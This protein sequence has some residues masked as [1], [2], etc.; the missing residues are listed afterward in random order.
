MRKKDW[1]KRVASAV[2]AAAMVVSQIGVW[3]AG[4]G[5]EVVKAEETNLI[6]NGD[7]SADASGWI[8]TTDLN[9][10]TNPSLTYGYDAAGG[11]N[12]AYISN[13]TGADSHAYFTQTIGS[14]PA[15]T[16]KF[17]AYSMGAGY[18][19]MQAVVGNEKVGTWVN[20]AVYSTDKSSWAKL[21]YTFTVSEAKTDYVVGLY[22]WTYTGGQ[23]TYLDDISLVAVSEQELAYNELQSTISSCESLVGSDYTAESW[24]TLQ[25]ALSTAQAITNTSELSE[26]QDAQTGLK[27]AIA[28][29]EA[30]VIEVYKRD[31]NGDNETLSEWNSSLTTSTTSKSEVADSQWKL[32]SAETT[33]VSLSTTVENLSTGEY[34]LSFVAVGGEMT[35]ENCKVFLK[36]SSQQNE[37]NIVINEWGGYDLTTT[38]L[39]RL[40]TDG[41][42]TIEMVYE[43]LDTNGGGWCNLDDIVLYK[44]VTLEEKKA[45]ELA[46]LNTLIAACDTLNSANYSASTWTAFSSAL[47]TARAVA[48]A[49]GSTLDDISTATKNLKSAKAALKESGIYVQKVEGLSNDFIRGVD[50]S[51]YVSI[52]ESGA[53]FKD[54]NGNVLNDAEFFQLL[55]NSGVNYVRVRIWNDPYTADSNKNGYG[56]GNSDLEK[57]KTI[58]KLA[59]DAGMKTLVDFHYSDFWADPE[60]QYSPKAW[61]NYTTSGNYGEGC[62][63]GEYTEKTV[64]EKEVLLYNYTYNSLKELIEYGVDVGMVQVGNETNNGM[65]GVSAAGDWANVCKL[66][67][68][69]SEAVRQVA[70]D[71]G[72]EILVA[73]HFTDP[74]TIG[75][76]DEIAGHLNDN[77][78]DYD[79]FASSYY[80]NIHGSMENL[81]EVLSG[82][83]TKYDKKVMVAETA[84]AWT[85]KDGDGHVTTFDP[86]S[87]PD[88]SISVQG[89]ANEIRDVVQA[90]VNVKDNAG[91]GV[92][93]W[94]PAWI[95]V[96]YAYDE[97]GNL[98]TTIQA[99]NQNLWA[100]YGSGWASIYSGEYDPEHGGPYYGGSVKDA[101]SFFDFEGN[102]LNSLTIFNDIYT[103]RTGIGVE[104]D[105][106][107]NAE[108]EVLLQT[109]NVTSALDTIKAAL[110]G[111]V[112]GINNDSTRVSLSVVWDSTKV[113]AINDFGSYSIPGTVSYQDKEGNSKTASVS[114][115]LNVLPKSIVTNGDF[116][117]GE[118][119]WTVSNAGNVSIV[120]ND[121]P[122][123]GTGA[124]HYWSAN[125][126]DFTLTQNVT[127]AESGIY[128]ASLQGQGGDGEPNIIGIQIKNM[129]TQASKEASATLTGWSVWKKPVA[130]GLEVQAGDT[131]QI[132]ITVS[133]AAGGWG[134]IDDVFLYKIG[135]YTAP[136]GG[137][138]SST[139]TPSTPTTPETPS[140]D[141]TTTTP[142]DTTVITNPDGT[143]TETKMETVTNE[144]GKAVTVTT[145]T[146][147]DAEGNVTGITETSVIENIVGKADATVMVE[148]N[149]AGEITSA[150]AVVDKSGA[151]T[152]TGVKA[153]L[154]GSVVP[155][156]TEAAGTE[157]VEIVMTVT[158]GKKEYTIKADAADI[159]AG[160]KLKVMAIDPKTGK[161]VLVNAKTYTVSKSG[162]IKVT[163]PEGATYQL[164]DSKDAA[165]VEKEILAT[166]KVKKTSATV[167]TGKKTTVQMSSKLDM[168]NVELITY[169]TSKKSVATVSK[170]GK[171]TAKKA[172]TVTI[173]VI[174]T[175]KNGQTKTVKMKVKVK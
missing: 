119:G 132:T 165:A 75:K 27:A 105:V 115:E 162:N 78:V 29:L 156:I 59:A 139:G 90:V 3:N 77:K 91:I 102:P 79:V 49:E 82:V 93:Y 72:K 111:T 54:E 164:L 148:K 76:Y 152:K 174:V 41:S 106:I 116:E 21:E 114:C 128:R 65:A 7:F 133:A 129:R 55:K 150:Q 45:Y 47:E 30:L 35:T 96:Q 23:W 98:N 16:Y 1:K 171:V 18:S 37:K 56:G 51:S 10:T 81:T 83:A 69:G 24:S 31:F 20:P 8:L 161:Y 4:V 88:Y 32:W 12:A 113:D 19:G 107:K 61:R 159:T 100:Q 92:F 172:G 43:M 60:R 28:G 39:F 149:A 64:E 36:A 53:T 101:E 143:I 175:L 66:Y 138:S 104:I 117:A 135:E 134:S 87:N 109:S 126:V 15:G 33:K 26:I 14:L 40:E 11:E 48:N 151:N 154:S 145:E 42:I 140:T 118:A 38:E 144:A 110:P 160:N 123:R 124:M 158:A 136:S 80:P 50:I 142:D 122:L 147:K 94:E 62:S 71:K 74:Q 5:L 167:E 17:T 58:G 85:T 108:V 131:V 52:T 121:T 125:I 9:G 95:P 137:S 2:L 120:W 57:A 155:Q 97:N 44:K 130:E 168:D 89:Q 63:D 173:K 46:E 157:S 73:V 153:T 112:T 127:V 68:K 6:T 84:W 22:L 86:G 99:S 170:N 25:T 70:K 67:K 13:N 146:Q 103:G 141:D 34:F 169:S 166:V 163:L